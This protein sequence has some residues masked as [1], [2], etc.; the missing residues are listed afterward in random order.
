MRYAHLTEAGA[1]VLS[2]IVRAVAL[3]LDPCDITSIDNVR[4]Q[5]ALYLWVSR[6]RV[7]RR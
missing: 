4:W 2:G 5:Y 6:Y 3:N 7:A 1:T